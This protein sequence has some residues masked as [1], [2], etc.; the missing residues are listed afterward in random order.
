[1]MPKNK[2]QLTAIAALNCL[3]YMYYEH[4]TRGTQR[5]VQKNVQKKQKIT[6]KKQ[7]VQLTTNTCTSCQSSP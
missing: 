2:Q 3:L 7:K 6:S 4:R 5:K 1:M